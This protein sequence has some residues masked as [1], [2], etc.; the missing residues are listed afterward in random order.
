[1]FAHRWLVIFFS[2][3]EKLDHAINDWLHLFHLPPYTEVRLS[4]TLNVVV[5]ILMVPTEFCLDFQ[6]RT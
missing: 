3:M 6:L 4:N 1:M 2:Y 5:T